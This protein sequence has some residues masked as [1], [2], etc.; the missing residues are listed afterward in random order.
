MDV[1]RI[2]M[3]TIGQTPRVDLVPEI[4]KLLPVGIEV[5][6]KGALD[7]LTLEE[8]ERFEPKEDDVCF[9]TRM[10]DGTEVT[11]GRSHILPRLQERISELDQEGVAVI[12]LLCSGEQ[13]NFQSEK[14]LIRPIELQSGVLSSISIKN[15]LGVMVPLER[16]ID[17]CVEAF[18]GLGFRTIGVS[19]SPYKNDKEKAIVEAA[20]GLMEEV[21]LIFMNCFGYTLEMKRKVREI[22]G[23]P[24]I[25]VRSLLA[26]LLGELLS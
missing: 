20:K 16:Q 3:V 23:K 25:L 9:V 14:P 17:S 21:D 12:A 7:G 6:E 19:F 4:K 24:V 26:R 2:G 22:T 18:Q 1:T 11:I 15:R 8:V 10:R 13:P 5:I